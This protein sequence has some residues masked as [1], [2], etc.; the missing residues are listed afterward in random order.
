M[1]KNSGTKLSF[2]GFARKTCRRKCDEKR[3]KK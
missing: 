2:A 1:A 3:R